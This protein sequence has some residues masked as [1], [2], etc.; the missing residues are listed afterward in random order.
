FAP[1]GPYVLVVMVEDATSAADARATIVDVSAAVFAAQ[2]ASRGPATGIADSLPRPAADSPP[3]G[4]ADSPPPHMANSLQPRIAEQAWRVPD[5]QGRLALLGDPR[6][7][8]APVPD[9][10]LT[11]ADDPSEPLRLRPELFPDLAALQRA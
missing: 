2:D 10:I 7:E 4:S 8:T 11:A 5:G 9:T 3:P 6:T 1:S